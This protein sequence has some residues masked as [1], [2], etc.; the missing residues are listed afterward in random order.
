MNKHAILCEKQESLGLS[1]LSSDV[2]TLVYI[3]ADTEY[4]SSSWSVIRDFDTLDV[5]IGL[6][7][8]WS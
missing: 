3:S 4:L 7:D 5:G 2:I 1:P 6:G 8:G